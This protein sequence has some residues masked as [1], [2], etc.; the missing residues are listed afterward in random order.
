MVE[1]IAATSVCQASIASGLRLIAL[2][3]FGTCPWR[4]M[5]AS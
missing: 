5:L 3:W 1:R 4:A 2:T